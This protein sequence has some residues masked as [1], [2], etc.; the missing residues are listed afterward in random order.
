MKLRQLKK[1]NKRHEERMRKLHISKCGRHDRAAFFVKYA[2][3]PGTPEAVEKEF[4]EALVKAVR[5]PL[6]IEASFNDSLFPGMSKELGC[7]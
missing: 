4:V 7:L 1:Q 2:T 6:L 5:R 3:W